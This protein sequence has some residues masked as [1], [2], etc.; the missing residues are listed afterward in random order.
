MEF[1]VL[2]YVVFVVLGLSIGVLGGFFGVGGAFI[3]TPTLNILGIPMAN[4]IATGLAF[5]VAVSVLAGR[6]H[7]LAGTMLLRVSLFVGLMSTAGLRLSTPLVLLLDEL[8]VAGP[9]IRIVYIVLL[10]ALGL[11]IVRQPNRSLNPEEE[12]SGW[13]H[14]LRSLPPQITI[15]AGKAVSFWSLL[16]IAVVVGFLQG[17]MGVGGG[18]VLVPLFI[19]VLDMEPHKA[20]GSS[21]GVIF[22]SASF[23]TY[24]YVMSGMVL[25][26]V[27]AMLAAGTVL[28]TYIGTRSISRIRGSSLQR[29]YG[30]F[31]LLS[32]VGIVFRQL[33]WGTLSL[34]YTLTLTFLVTLF[35]ILKYFIGLPIPLFNENPAE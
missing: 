10:I 9:Y 5:T 16:L 11:L 14:R 4:A 19:L 3:L 25:F 35:I 13:T 34:A 30:L 6:K 24:F 33:E 21:L 22:I 15:D 7:Y 29:F 18:F 31:L 23:G 12:G 27:A 1:A 26:V 28:G 17:L 32:S 8:G 2:E 20:A